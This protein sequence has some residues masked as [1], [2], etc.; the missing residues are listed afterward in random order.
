MGRVEREPHGLVS[1]H[2]KQVGLWRHQISDLCLLIC[3][4]GHEKG[5]RKTNSQ[6]GRSR[7]SAIPQN[8]RVP[9]IP[10]DR[11]MERR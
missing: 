8:R 11:D 3:G 4:E 6:A 10:E 5:E 7:A 1:D 9:K 2:S